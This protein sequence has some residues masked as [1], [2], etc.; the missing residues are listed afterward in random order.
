MKKETLVIALGGNAIVRKG[1]KGTVT[2]QFAN[3]RL[4]LEGIVELI[5]RGYNIVLT[6]GNGPQVGNIL[7]RVEQSLDKAYEVPLGVCVAESEGEMGY[8]IE[9]SL[10]NKL[11]LNKIKRNVVTILTQVIVKKDD[12]S[13]KKP[14]FCGNIGLLISKINN[15]PSVAR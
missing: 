15:P 11:H 7:I 13:I 2:E 6:H 12:P 1:E 8:M 3:T 9:Q 5:K 10:Q 4:A 14:T